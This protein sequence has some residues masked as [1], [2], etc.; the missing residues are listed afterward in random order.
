M[1]SCAQG[2]IW[3]PKTRRCI[4]DTAANRRRVG[5]QPRNK[6]AKSSDVRRTSANKVR[7]S[8]NGAKTVLQLSKQ[9]A[10]FASNRKAASVIAKLYLQIADADAASGIQPLTPNAFIT[11]WLPE[12]LMNDRMHT[13]YFDPGQK[14]GLEHLL[15]HTHLKSDTVAFL[16]RTR[17]MTPAYRRQLLQKVRKLIQEKIRLAKRLVRDAQEDGD[18][19]EFLREQE[20]Y[21]KKMQNLS[22]QDLLRKVI[23]KYNKDRKAG[24]PSVVYAYPN[25]EDYVDHQF[26]DKL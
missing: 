13:L 11:D 16:S 8:R 14:I 4:A 17:G 1:N 9:F 26:R 15:R 2:K 5:L 23:K 22:E 21:L 3:N 12:A 25:A 24:D 19:E 6:R 18:D 10:P 20:A 7:S